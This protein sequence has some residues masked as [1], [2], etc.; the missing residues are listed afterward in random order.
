MMFV[1]PAVTVYT[2][3]VPSA[4]KVTLTAPAPEFATVGFAIAA[5]GVTEFDGFDVSDVSVPPL[6]DTVKVYGVRFVR[7]TTVQLCEPTGGV[8]FTVQTWLPEATV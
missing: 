4:V 5:E 2:V 8:V 3:A 6:E 7:P 1:I